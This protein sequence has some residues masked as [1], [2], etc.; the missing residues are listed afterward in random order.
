MDCRFRLD[1]LY[2]MILRTVRLPVSAGAINTLDWAPKAPGDVLP[3]AL[4][5]ADWLADAGLS[6]VSV[7]ASASSS[8]TVSGLSIVGGQVHCTIGGG[9]SGSSSYVRFLLTLSVGDALDVLVRLS[10][11]ST[12]PVGLVPVL[13]GTWSLDF[14]NG[15]NSA[16]APAFF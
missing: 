8:L 11:L 15:D 2:V 6:L 12:Y 16:Y 14:S 4:D 3:Y 5:C 1:A 7:A 13:S 10:I 9:L